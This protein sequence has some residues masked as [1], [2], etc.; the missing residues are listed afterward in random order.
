MFS[1]LLNELGMSQLFHFNVLAVPLLAI[2][3]I[4]LAHFKIFATFEVCE[5][6]YL[7]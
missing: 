7:I 3:I 4:S 1:N 2:L 5:L 6:Y